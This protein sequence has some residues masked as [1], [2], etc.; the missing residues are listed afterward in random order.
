MPND[1]VDNDHAAEGSR[2]KNQNIFGRPR[3]G[4]KTRESVR[5][6]EVVDTKV[7]KLKLDK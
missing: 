4:S 3:S 2:A 1:A 7:K 5:S 6:N